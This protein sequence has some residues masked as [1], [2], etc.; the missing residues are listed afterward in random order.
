MLKYLEGFTF[1]LVT[2][3]KISCDDDEPV[4]SLQKPSENQ[5]RSSQEFFGENLEVLL[6]LSGSFPVLTM[7]EDQEYT[8]SVGV[9]LIR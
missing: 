2:A 3:Y 6:V 7:W 9:W 8:A 5:S 1:P 4:S